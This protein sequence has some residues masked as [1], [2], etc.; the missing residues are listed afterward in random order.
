M[1][2]LILQINKNILKRYEPNL[3]EGT[4]FLF[5]I[6]SEEVWMGNA[7]AD[8]ILRLID[9]T[10]TLQEIYDMLFPLF[11]DF[12][13]EELTTSFNGIIQNLLD[14]GFLMVLNA[15]K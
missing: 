5:N 4:V 10:L 14:K 9:G 6:E 11:E 2:N 15:E 12:S 8:C 3:N 13:E 1:K 7:A